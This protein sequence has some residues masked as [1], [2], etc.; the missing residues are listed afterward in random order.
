MPRGME[1]FAALDAIQTRNLRVHAAA[2]A[3]YDFDA[4][5]PY[6]GDPLGKKSS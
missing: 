2:G 1:G 3:S 6:R 4:V 5:L